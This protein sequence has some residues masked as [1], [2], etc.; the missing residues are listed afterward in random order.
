MNDH[1]SREEL[2]ALTPGSLSAARAREILSHLLAPCV[3]CLDAAPTSLRLLLGLEPGPPELT[4]EED[5]AYDTAIE[6]AIRA[7]CK[8]DRHLQ[9]QRTEARKLERI[10]A[11]GGLEAVEKLP[12]KTGDLALFEALLARSWSLRHEN[13]RLM[14]QF[15]WLAV[16][17][18]ERLDAVRYGA[19]RVSDFQCRAHAELG[20]AYR[21]LDQLDSARIS[22]D[23]ARRL[24]ELG[25]G[26]RF[27]EVRMLELEA[28]LFADRRQFG[29]AR[30]NLLKAFAFHQD[31]GDAHLTGRALITLGLYT[32]N[33]GDPEEGISLV[34]RGADLLELGRDPALEHA[35][36]HNQL[37]FLVD[38]GRYGEARRFLFLHS[39]AFAAV[40][41]RLNR[42]R[43]RVLEGRID[44]G[45][46][47]RDRAEAIF[48][49]VVRGFTEAD[50]PYDAALFS[51][52]L[53]AALLAQHKAGEAGEVVL[54]ASQAFLRL[55][56]E[57]EALG[58]VMLLRTACEVRVATVAMVEEVKGYLRRIEHGPLTAFEARAWET[59][60]R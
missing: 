20:N 51:L 59:P 47:K 3:S 12:R 26:D 15:A 14:A 34:R 21:V 7:A 40:E 1:P 58:A 49:E 10:L 42:L 41:G 13:P 18:A 48:R 44:Y 32:G 4:A 24:F 36:L 8:L 46:Q 6:R 45:L 52:D 11:Q 28:S 17:A 43:L 5:A 55:G 25:T 16:K 60:G 54:E 22:L 19:E 27:L 39:A 35:A 29:P 33:A 30:N 2:S 57:R 50:R 31:S 9:G 38:C 37:H 23:D 56:I 53:A